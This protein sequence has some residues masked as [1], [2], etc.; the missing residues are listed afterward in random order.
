MAQGLLFVLSNMLAAAAAAWVA[1]VALA[2]AEPWRRLLAAVGGYFLA[3]YL[4]S[5][6][7]SA[8]GTLA[9]LPVTVGAGVCALVG[10]I[11][12]RRFGPAPSHELPNDGD[13]FV[14]IAGGAVLASVLIAYAARAV[15]GGT[16]FIFDDF[17]YHAVQPAYWV[18]AGR[19]TL[20]LGNYQSY[21][22][23]NAEM[24][25]AWLMLPYRADGQAGLACLYWA[26]LTAAAV[27]ALG[28]GQGLGG[29]ATVA[30]ALVLA[31]G[32][33]LRRQKTFSAADLAGPALALA[34]LAMLSPLSERASE[35][36][37]CYAAL[38][39]AGLF[40]GL[41]AGTK[42]SL[43]LVPAVGALWLL[44]VWTRRRGWSAAIAA[45]A[46]FSA[47]AALT[48]GYWYLRNALLTGNPL[49]PLGNALLDGPFGPAEQ[50]RTRLVTWLVCPPEPYTWSQLAGYVWD[51]PL[52]I[53]LACLFG[54]GCG[55]WRA[56]SR[57]DDHSGLRSWVVLLLAIGLGSVALFPFTPFSATWEWP[58][59]P[60]THHNRYLI[61]PLGIGLALAGL[62]LRSTG[63]GS[64]AIGLGM[65][66]AA[67]ASFLAT[68]SSVWGP[69]A[70]LLALGFVGMIAA[71]AAAIA[72]AR[73]PG[74]I[75]TLAVGACLLVALALLG[76]ARQRLTDRSLRSAVVQADW[77]GAGE[78]MSS[79]LEFIET[80]PPGARLG[81]FAVHPHFCYPFFGR[82]LQFEPVDLAADGRA[83]APLHVRWRDGHPEGWWV[84]AGSVLERDAELRQL[85]AN[86]AESGVNYVI[87][88]KWRLGEWPPQQG[89]L[90]NGDGLLREVY[91][92]GY[93]AVWEA[94]S[95]SS[96]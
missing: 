20:G 28:R 54:Y 34:A 25:S 84:L 33:V 47:C 46:L 35:R 63:L 67:C 2:S 11:A 76:P 41:A 77:T 48:G 7:T 44:L 1:R 58:D 13:R 70:P 55:V 53:L 18:R 38:A 32:V 29:A 6:A 56:V 3:V 61:L 49:F 86:L 45:T 4:V 66:A 9:A 23:H 92:D 93:S 40:A 72:L 5:L 89:A 16:P 85:S 19:L 50:A 82:R 14:A 31:S 22:P 62:A 74:S 36:R 17:S 60:L 64:R 73:A 37:C 91:N 39:Y 42:A 81:W 52:P 57:R 43:L 87:V 12:C 8:F 79:L 30:A 10:W 68:L 95:A 51:W 59:S 21:Y 80:L 83:R 90:E 71:A 15:L 88:T 75:T 65:L 78:P 94:P 26:L 27:Y 24:L 96:R 69:K